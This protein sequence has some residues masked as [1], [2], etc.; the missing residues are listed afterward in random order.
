MFQEK[1]NTCHISEPIIQKTIFFKTCATSFT[2]EQFDFIQLCNETQQQFARF[3]RLFRSVMHVIDTCSLFSLFR[4]FLS[5]FL[6]FIK[7]S[8]CWISNDYNQLIS[9]ILYPVHLCRIIVKYMRRA[10]EKLLQHV[11]KI[12]DYWCTT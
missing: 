4:L 10:E 5:F 2:S 12:E 9:I 11:F 3:W 8:G 7:M 1:S 6:D